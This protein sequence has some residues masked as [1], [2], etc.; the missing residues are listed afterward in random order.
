MVKKMFSLVLFSTFVFAETPKTY[1][2][3]NHVLLKYTDNGTTSDFKPTGFKWTAGYLVKDFDFVSFGLEA[4]AMLGVNNDSKSSVTLSNGNTLTNA[5]AS[6]DKLYNIQ[7]KTIIPLVDKLNANV[8][9]GGSRVKMLTNAD[10]FTG[11]SGWN[12]AFSYGAGL[13]YWFP[14]NISFN[15]DYMQ[16][17]KNLNALEIGVGFKF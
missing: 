10:S 1:I 2:N 6:L 8:Y 5:Q 11:S 13:E 4:S 17:F 12:S 15:L 16:Y 3:M 14:S 9:L 7:L